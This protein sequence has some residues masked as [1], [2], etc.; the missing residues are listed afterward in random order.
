MNKLFAFLIAFFLLL[1][2]VAVGLWAAGVFEP[3][4][5][6]SSSVILGVPQLGGSF[7]LVNQKGETVTDKS[8]RGKLMLIFFGYTNCPDVCPTEMQDIALTMQQL[9]DD[10]ADVV[11]IFITVD[12]TR[13]TPEVMADFVSAFDP[14]L[15][16]LSGTEKQIDDVKEKFRV[17]A[18]KV[19][20]DDPNYYL[21]NHTSYTYLMGRDGKL[22]TVF[23]YGTPPEK[24]AAK[25]RE[26]L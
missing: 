24:M 11:P 9:G 3:Q 14:S 8:Y 19:P 22:I 7:T 2:A 6:A 21:V 1:S 15:V 16:G 13:D 23:S 5:K 26:Q 25:I 10:A 12:P 4:E 18:E 20:G 17:Y